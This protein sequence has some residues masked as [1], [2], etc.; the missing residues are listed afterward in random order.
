MAKL[1]AGLHKPDGLDT[2]TPDNLIDTYKGLDLLALPGI[3]RRFKARLYAAGITSPY[4]MFQAE[5]T[6]LKSQVF[7]SILGQHW[8]LRLRGWEVDDREFERKTIGHQYALEH[9]TWDRDE[10][11]RLLMKLCEKTGRRLRSNELVAGGVHLYIRFVNGQS[12]HHGC[13]IF[14][15]LYATQDIYREVDRLLTSVSQ[16]PDNVSHLSITVFNLAPCNP[17]Q[18]GLFDG[19]GAIVAEGTPGAD[20][21]GSLSSIRQKALARAADTVNDRYGEFTIIP[22]IMAGMDKTILDR[23]AFGNIRDM[24]G[25]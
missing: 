1:A 9:K 18:L 13:K 11:R 2:L 15:P 23:V 17:E 16:F 25:G 7:F 6:F 14:H 4:E 5:A 20:S 12:W 3:N 8:H 19:S 21:R 24:S 22:A 10:L